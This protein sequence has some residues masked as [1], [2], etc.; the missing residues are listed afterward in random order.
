MSGCSSGGSESQSTSSVMLLKQLT[1][2]QTKAPAGIEFIELVD[3]NVN[4]VA[5]QWVL[6]PNFQ[7]TDLQMAYLHYGPTWLNVRG[8][9]IPCWADF[10]EGVSTT[11]AVDEIHNKDLAPKWWDTNLSRQSNVFD[12]QLTRMA[13]CAFRYCMNLVGT[14]SATRRRQSA[15]TPFTQWNPLLSRESFLA[16]DIL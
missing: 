7:I 5:K 4:F 13:A 10:P 12:V 11:T 14:N 9:N 3:N 16:I 8:R 15:G 2:L 6:I 1:E